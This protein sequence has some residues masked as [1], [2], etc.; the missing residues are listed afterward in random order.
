MLV[1]VL[2]KQTWGLD[3]VER[4]VQRSALF[5]AL[6]MDWIRNV[7]SRDPGVLILFPSYLCTSS[8]V[9]VYILLRSA[10]GL[11][12]QKLRDIFVVWQSEELIARRS[13]EF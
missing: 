3:G 2:G 8:G 4:R 12:V 1:L 6:E 13:S 7:R 11:I 9:C 10:S 5:S